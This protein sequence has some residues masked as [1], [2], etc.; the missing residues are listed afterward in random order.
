MS[1]QK[2]Q[3]DLEGNLCKN[4][5]GRGSTTLKLSICI[6]TFC[7]SN[8]FAETVESILPQLTPECEIVVVDAG[9]TDDTEQIALK[10]SARSASFRYVRQVGNNGIDRDYDTAV[11]LA[12]GDYCWLMTDDDLLKPEGVKIV[13]AALRS[14]PSLVVANVER[15]D[16]T[17]SNVVQSRWLDLDVDRSYLPD[18]IERLFVDVV[19]LLKYIGCVIIRRS[20]WRG[21][22]RSSYYGSYFVHVGVIFQERLP[23]HALVVARP[24]VSQRLGNTHTFSPKLG[25]I[26][27]SKWPS[28]IGSLPISS[29]EK[30]KVYSAEPWGHLQMLLV[31]RATGCYS[32]VDYRRWIRPHLRSS[33]AQ[34]A[35]ILVAHVPGILV[36]AALATFCMVKR[37]CIQGLWWPGMMQQSVRRSMDRARNRL[38]GL[39]NA[40]RQRCGFAE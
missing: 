12:R 19:D 22:D 4:G 18:E 11:E 2:E 17:M 14:D 1:R 36:R 20:I 9:S 10:I 37:R 5:K 33:R 34:F 39:F 25:E 7:R 40:V 6:T 15:R 31:Y 23:G 27:Y 13:L 32:F 35:G 38:G 30:R 8:Y 3:D 21:R 26:L 24:L 16:L 28:L 29:A